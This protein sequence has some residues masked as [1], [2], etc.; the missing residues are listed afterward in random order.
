MK[1]EDYRAQMPEYWEGALEE[2]DKVALEMHL[3]SC[4]GCRTEAE[5]LGSIWHGLARIP[6]AQPSRDLR[7]R[8]YERLDAYQQGLMESPATAAPSPA[9]VAHPSLVKRF[10]AWLPMRPAFQ[11]AFSAALLA[12]GFFAGFRVDD[13]RD[14]MQISQLRSEVSNMRQMVT[15][16]LLQ[17]QNASERLKGVNWSY[18]VEQSDTEVLSALLYTVNHDQNVNVRL[19]AVDALRTFSDS[20]IARKGLLQ[21]ISKQDSPMVQVSLIDTLADIRDREA[22]PLLQALSKDLK[23]NPEV[24]ERAQWAL[25]RMH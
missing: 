21:A 10:Q 2:E 3:A 16:S 4:T 23:S 14:N 9:A 11:L 17:Q 7:R 5:S 22:M 20:P 1:C 6:L 13:K 24:R 25:G 18:R 19:A 15:L 8:F 12:I